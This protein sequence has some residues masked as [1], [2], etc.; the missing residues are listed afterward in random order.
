MSTQLPLIVHEKRRGGRPRLHVNDSA[1][2]RAYRQRLKERAIYPPLPPGPYRVLYAD[3]PWL[4]QKNAPTFHGNAADRYD[5]FSIPQLCALPVRKI[6]EQSAVLFL[7]VTSPVL[8]ECF[9]V[10]KAWGFTYKTDI[11]WDKGKMIHGKYLGNQHELLLLCTR[12]RCRPEV[13]ELDANVRRIAP[14]AHS[15]KPEEF[16]LLIDHLYPT[17]RRLELFAR[18]QAEGWDVW[19]N[20]VALTSTT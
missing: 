16:R 3:P 2:K 19:G 11:I 8:P 20:Q 9:P 14:T 18:T 12:G 17:G 5:P 15:R 13:E 10:I 4:Y 1:K 7:W 6:V